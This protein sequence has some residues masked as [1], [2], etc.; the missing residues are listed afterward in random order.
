MI[1]CQELRQRL[2]AGW[3]NCLPA[4]SA[5]KICMLGATGGNLTYLPNG[6]IALGPGRQLE[7]QLSA[8]GQL[9]KHRKLAPAGSLALLPVGMIALQVPGPP[10]AYCSRRNCLPPASSASMKCRHLARQRKRTVWDLY[11]STCDLTGRAG[12]QQLPPA[13]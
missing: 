13:N 6:M 9:R 4:S 7:H 2:S 12:R 3:N 5:L 11:Q 10:A 8:C 1:N